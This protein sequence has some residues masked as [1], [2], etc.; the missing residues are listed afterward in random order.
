MQQQNEAEEQADS[1]AHIANLFERYGK[2]IFSY[3]RLHA[4]STEEAEDVTLDVFVA[5]LEEDN[6][7][8]RQE[9]EQLAW[10]RRV[11]HNKLVDRYRK[12]IRHPVVALDKIS[13]GLF[14]DDAHSPEQLAMRRELYARVYE[15]I[16]ALPIPQQQLL[17]LHYG[18]GLRLAEIAVLFNKREEAVRKMHSRILAF[19]R[20]G[21]SQFQKERR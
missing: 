6:L 21:L 18:D 9:Q 20:T 2:A 10:L 13:E 19:L 17:K 11:A 16:K 5:A 4:P 12:L 7:S 8:A 3:V 15:D 14:D 1:D